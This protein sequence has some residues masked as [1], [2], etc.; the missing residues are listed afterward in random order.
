[1]NKNSSKTKQ[2]PKTMEELVARVAELETLLT[3]KDRE[4]SDLE[5]EVKEKQSDINDLEFEVEKR[6]KHWESSI[7][8]REQAAMQAIMDAL[9]NPAYETYAQFEFRRNLRIVFD[10]LEESSVET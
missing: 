8:D 1:M 6:E 2:T 9:P 7:G 4:I 5:D 3:K 10:A